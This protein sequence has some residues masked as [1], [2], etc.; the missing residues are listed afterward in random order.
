MLVLAVFSPV[1]SA[2]S[3]SISCFLLYFSYTSAGPA[4]IAVFSKTGAVILN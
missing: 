1:I 2:L 4:L 3:N